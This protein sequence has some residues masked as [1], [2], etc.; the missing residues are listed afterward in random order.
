MSDTQ[1]ITVFHAFSAG[2][3]WVLGTMLCAGV[4]TGNTSANRCLG[5][6]FYI[7]G[8]TFTQLFFEG[9]E[10]VGSFTIHLLELPRWA[11][12]PCFY[13]AV[14]RYTSPSARNKYELLHFIPFLFFLAFSLTQIIP[15]LLNK[16]DTSLALPTWLGFIARYLFFAQM[17][18]YWIF[19]FKLFYQH[20]KNIKEL[21]SFTEKI[22]L[23]WIK[24]LLISVLILISIRIASSY[25]AQISR[26]SPILYFIG[27]IY[28]AYATL[29]Q[30]SIY[31]TEKKEYAGEKDQVPA[32]KIVHE[33]LTFDQVEELKRVVQQRTVDEKLYLD[34]GLTLVML[35]A[36]I[37]IRVHE[38]SYVLNNGL[39]KN[40][41]QFINELRAEEAK[42]L[43]LSAE[44]KHLDMTGVA[45][46]AGFN[47]KTTFYT[48]F[49]KATNLTPKEYIKAKSNR[50]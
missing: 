5:I 31:T 6:F 17:V 4:N 46:R 35:S 10:T 12:L 14:R 15:H 16:N 41:Y 20:Q 43:L 19:C 2:G 24:Y 8:G 45:I 33:R 42:V 39:K 40:F 36:K 18:Y 34:P 25:V 29:T 1:L 47:S 23:S 30:K 38:L 32:G 7:L 13:F 22:D 11:M 37:G 3:L 49:K 48:T 27:V 50:I 21:A 44:T 26:Y 9:F 28:L